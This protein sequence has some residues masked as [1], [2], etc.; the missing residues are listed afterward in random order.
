[1]PVRVNKTRQNKYSVGPKRFYSRAWTLI[2]LQEFNSQSV[3]RRSSFRRKPK[4]LLLA[5]K[6]L[7]RSA[8]IRVF[9]TLTNCK[10]NHGKRYSVYYRWWRF[11][12]NE[13][14]AEILFAEL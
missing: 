5:F 1:M 14:R 11:F 8:T 12:R 13:I 6:L 3:T 4:I 7:Q 9:A 10:D 2:A